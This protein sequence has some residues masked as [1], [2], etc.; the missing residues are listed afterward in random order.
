MVTHLS[1]L[2]LDNVP[3][4]E[5]DLPDDTRDG[6]PKLKGGTEPQ[7]GAITV[8][9][10]VA[11]PEFLQGATPWPLS[12]TSINEHK[13]LKLLELDPDRFQELA[14]ISTKGAAKSHL[15]VDDVPAKARMLQRRTM[16]AWIARIYPHG[17]RFSGANLNP[18]P[19]WLVG[20]QAVAL[21]MGNTDDD[22]RVDMP[23]QFHYA[24]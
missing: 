6:A 4:Q 11:V 1:S 20:A 17:L 22:V 13:M 12:V 15:S 7:L 9:R 2:V 24:L 3:D 16:S 19:F 10:S 21:N 14:G 23:L 18:L 8:L 5:E